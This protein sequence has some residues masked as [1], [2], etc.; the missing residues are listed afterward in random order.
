MLQLRQADINLDNGAISCRCHM[1]EGK[2]SVGTM[3]LPLPN[4]INFINAYR[5]FRNLSENP[6]VFS[7]VV[8]EYILYI[9]LMIVLCVDFHRLWIALHYGVTTRI[10]PTTGNSEGESNQRKPLSKVS[11]VPPERMPAPHVYQITVTT[12]SMF[13]AG[14]ASRVGFQLYGSEGTSPV[15]MLNPE[16]EAL[17]RGSTLH[18][19][20][21]VRESLGEVMLL[22]IWH[23][24]SG[25]GDMASWFLGSFV[26]RDVEKDVVSYF[27]CND[28]L[29]AE[30]G[31][32]EVQKVVHASTEEELT[33]FT[34][35]FIEATKNAFYDKQ[36]WA[37]VLVAAPGS[38]F[39]KAQRLSCCFTLLNTMMLASAMWYREENK[40][41]DTRVFNL[42]FVRF[43]IE[44][45]Y[46]SVM[47]TLT[48]LPVNWMLLQLFRMEEPLC[49]N[50]PEMSIRPAKQGY[51]W[52][53]L[54]RLGK[55]VAWVTVFLVSSS[56]AFFVILYS[57]D[58]GK[59]KSD[60]WIKAFIMSFMG[61]SCV[62]DTLQIFVLA[63]ALASIL[64]LPLLAKPP[65][66]RKEDL[67]LNLWNTTG[68]NS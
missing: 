64:S 67:Q 19:V 4:S 52:K 27:N 5:N 51:L 53:T 10:S 37:S 43:T 42:G 25:E 61:S 41:A 48:I 18:F 23:D 22:H 21:P 59:E 44:E 2:V 46:I 7:I 33:S 31:D 34:N 16:G 54:F 38:S 47:T 15:K 17:V 35:V 24:N 56:S 11:L 49:A 63:V 13:S 40:T 3:T 66:I 20:M 55:L 28:W 9:L 68:K 50:S 57:M 29:S 30:K 32:C 26:V 60:S 39:T 14:T 8:S 12:G 45:L 36:L 58:W 6:V 65:T 1:T 62:V